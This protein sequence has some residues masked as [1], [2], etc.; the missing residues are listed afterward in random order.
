VRRS[1]RD[2]AGSV[3][4]RVSPRPALLLFFSL[5][6]VCPLCGCGPQFGA[7]RYFFGT[8]PKQTVQAKFKPTKGTLL[9]LF[10]DSP[11]VD[12]PPEMREM[13]VRAITDE[14]KK[15]AVNEKIVPSA[16]L[17]ELRQQRRDVNERGTPRGIREMG[18][19]V[20]AEQVLW[21]YPKEFSMA[22]TPEQALDPARLTVVLKVINAQAEDRAQIRL[23][24]LSEEGELVSITIPSHKV[25]DAKTPDDLLRTMAETLAVEIGRLFRDYEEGRAEDQ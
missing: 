20:N 23:W 1:P 6:S 21:L 12:L 7:L 8:M 15:N 25:R 16:K 9:V 11:V 3:H 18:R 24:P 10:D 13:V 4:L 14:F 5:L 2:G 22:G 19:M 17:N